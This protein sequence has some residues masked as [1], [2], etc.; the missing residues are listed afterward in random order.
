MRARMLAA[1][2][3]PTASAARTESIASAGAGGT[4]GPSAATMM[5]AANDAAT[6][7]TATESALSNCGSG[8]GTGTCGV[9]RP[10]RT[11]PRVVAWNACKASPI[12]VLVAV[13]TSLGRTAADDAATLSRTANSEAAA[14]N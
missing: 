4:A 8:A 11:L 13:W 9:L 6:L 5:R 2:A 1:G 12:V 10:D 3:S 7:R 14:L